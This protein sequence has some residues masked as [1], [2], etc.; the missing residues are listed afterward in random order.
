MANRL[1]I[2]FDPDKDSFQLVYGRVFE[3]FFETDEY[4]EVLVEDPGH[5]IAHDLESTLNSLKGI[6]ATSKILLASAI[7]G[8]SVQGF[9]IEKP[10]EGL[11]LTR[12]RQVLTPNIRYPAL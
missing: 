1:V 3:V 12:T 8:T 7:G 6:Y 5:F 10:P 2:G 9:R 4:D 11:L